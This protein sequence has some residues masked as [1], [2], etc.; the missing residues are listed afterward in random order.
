MHH[1]TSDILHQQ[2]G[3]DGNRIIQGVTAELLP[4]LEH[5][6]PNKVKYTCPKSIWNANVMH[7]QS[8]AFCSGGTHHVISFFCRLSDSVKKQL[9]HL[10]EEMLRSNR[11]MESAC[12]NVPRTNFTFGTAAT[13]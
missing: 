3:E 9:N 1:E 12:G 4:I 8:A 2:I 10:F 7:R 5:E 13:A 6:C 11:Q